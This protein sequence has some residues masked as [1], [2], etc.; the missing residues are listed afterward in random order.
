MIFSV[1]FR[2]LSNFI[3]DVLG[4][5]KFSIEACQ[6]LRLT[7]WRAADEGVDNF[8]GEIA[9]RNYDQNFWPGKSLILESQLWRIRLL[10]SSR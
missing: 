9:L 2:I 8:V 3:A 5:K 7:G 10:C 6:M 1:C 4:K